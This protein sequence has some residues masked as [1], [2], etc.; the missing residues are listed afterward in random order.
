[1]GH[2]NSGTGFADEGVAAAGSCRR[3]AWAAEEEKGTTARSKSD[4]H[5]YKRI[6]DSIGCGVARPIQIEWSRVG[7]GYLNLGRQNWIEWL[8]LRTGSRG[9]RFN[10]GR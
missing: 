5:D 4:D 3:S 10:L 6:T 1:M 7:L 9:S 8:I 2:S